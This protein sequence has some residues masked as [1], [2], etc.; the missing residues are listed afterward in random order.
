MISRKLGYIRVTTG[1]YA[2]H[3]AIFIWKGA[4][5]IATTAIIPIH[6]GKGR[7]VAKALKDVTDYMENPLKTNNGEFISSYECAPETAETEFLL[8]KSR[9]L[10]LTGLDQK[11]C[12]V[13]AY[14]ARQSFMP[15]E[16]TPAE[17]NRIGYELAMRFTK[18]RH[19]FLVCTHTDRAHIHNH[20]V[21]NSTTLDCHRKFRDFFRSGR[22]LRRC[23]DILCAENG[24]SVIEN[25]Q[26]RRGKNYA[27]WL[28]DRKPLSFQDKLRFAID[29]ALDKK[30]NNFNEFLS[31]MRA[32][33]YEINEKRKH[34]TFLAPGQKQP[35][36]CDTLRGSHTEEA[37]R[38]RIVGRLIVS[39]P[40]GKVQKVSEYTGRTEHTPRTT[41]EKPN[42]LIDI[43]AKMREGKGA[44]YQRWAKIHNL[45]QMAKTL[46]YLQEKGLDNY[47]V[48]KEKTSDASAR[49]NGLSS[50]IRELDAKLTA[51]ASL[52][53]Q[54]V[55]YS[56]TRATYAEYKK[57]KW[58]KS[59][60]A[61]HE[62]D[63]ILHQTAKKAFDDLGYGRDKKLPTVASL[64]AEYD[65]MLEEKRN[66]YKEYHQVKS[67]M[68]ELLTAKATVDRLLNIT[69]G[70]IERENE[71]AE[72]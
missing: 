8:A 46:I 65:P 56:K 34:I 19:A 69:T 39:A 37:I 15:G 25:P 24:L 29:E 14:H 16:I 1:V 52:Q 67:E 31:L 18:G 33:G 44:G 7:S 64:R 55:T 59:F 10:D 30:P 36:R 22:A 68:Q 58:S 62:A 5:N 35:T 40:A 12:D 48:L 72:R 43:E 32:T 63:I 53:K 51:N 11:K 28:G 47:D 9:Y 42:L 66:A 54:I 17:A 50:R 4:T 27:E 70:N 6:A 45:K 13:I 23:S 26:T 2:V 49:F 41:V 60:R 21:W 3:P 57:S 38:E 20:I 71:R 61:T